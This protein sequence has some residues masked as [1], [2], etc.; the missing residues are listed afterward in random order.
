MRK[1]RSILLTTC[2]VL[3]LGVVLGSFSNREVQATA[4][5]TYSYVHLFTEVLDEVKRNYVEEIDTKELV[6]SSI[7]GMMRDLD[8][9]SVFLD[10]SAY[11][12]LRI[13]TKGS[14]GGLGIVISIRDGFLTVISPM[15]GTPA[16]AKGIQA[17]DRIV[18]IEGESTEGITTEE[19]V[20]QLRGPK[21]TDVTITI[22]RAGI[23][24][25]FDYT[26]TRDVIEIK[27]IPFVGVLGDNIGYVRLVNFSE[28]AGEELSEAIEGLLAQGVSGLV[29][30][31]RNNSGGLLDQ[32]VAVA[33]LFVPK[34]KLVV[35]T[36]GRKATDNREWEASHEPL[37]EN[38]PL[39]VLVNGGTAS[40]SEIVSGAIQ[41]YDLGVIMGVP[42]Y[43]K[44]SV[45]TVRNLSSGTALKLTTAL[46]YTPSGRSIHRPEHWRKA[47]RKAAE[48]AAKTAVFYTE[49]GR[50]IRGGGG[51]TPDVEVDNPEATRLLVDILRKDLFFKFV[52]NE[53]ANEEVHGDVIEVGDDALKRFRALLDSEE[54]EY[55]EEEFAAEKDYI[56]ASIRRQFAT[57]LMGMEAGYRYGLEADRQLQE[58]LDFLAGVHQP[59]ELWAKVQ[60]RNALAAASKADSAAAVVVAAPAQ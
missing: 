46:Y 15:E 20:T 29:F 2:T 43:G 25:T 23:P 45:Q 60:A 37:V 53:T 56:V 3:F 11:S 28:V 22:A 47:D 39:V 41:D 30:D 35:Y 8:A 16:W 49:A 58:A 10:E 57:K 6:Y 5:R 44:G 52:V 48:E 1:T 9:H 50:E 4:S 59:A 42:T 21:G 19:A 26:I 33:D 14:F 36:K 31:L 38:L 27:A 24:D 32:A 55:T 12:E 40:A 54:I 7:R 34:N 13:D 17:G 18:A 51:I